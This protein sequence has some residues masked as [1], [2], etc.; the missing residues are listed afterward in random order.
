VADNVGV[1]YYCKRPVIHVKERDYGAFTK[2]WDKKQNRYILSDFWHSECYH[3]EMNKAL[4]I[5]RGIHKPEY[6]QLRLF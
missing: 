1:C 2:R 3:R 4:N 5:M 6:E